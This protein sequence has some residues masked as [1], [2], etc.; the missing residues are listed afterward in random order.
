MSLAEKPRKA[1]RPFWPE[2]NGA[3]RTSFAQL[4]L[5]ARITRVEPGTLATGWR[6]LATCWFSPRN[7]NHESWLNNVKYG[8]IWENLFQNIPNIWE[9][10]W[11]YLL[12]SSA[13]LNFGLFSGMSSWYELQ[14]T[15]LYATRDAP[16]VSKVAEP[17]TSCFSGS[18]PSGKF[19]NK[20]WW[21]EGCSLGHGDMIHC[22]NCTILYPTMLQFLL[23]REWTSNPCMTTHIHKLWLIHWGTGELNGWTIKCQVCCLPSNK[24]GVEISW[25]FPCLYIS[26]NGVFSIEISGLFFLMGQDHATS[27]AN[28]TGISPT[29]DPHPKIDV[30]WWLMFIM[31]MKIL[32][33]NWF[34]MVKK[35]NML[36]QSAIL[37]LNAIVSI[38][39]FKRQPCQLQQHHM[40]S[41][42]EKKTVPDS[43]QTYPLVNVHI[44]MENHHV[45]WVN[46]L[47]QWPFSIANC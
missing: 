10:T 36:K 38:K 14:T 47:F 17:I 30:W 32:Y 28:I 16:P 40:I 5:M 34:D 42:A 43:R 19:H 18:I 25:V 4:A 20:T 27:C 12:W 39:I 3:F 22:C 44:T 41:W 7:C 9:N 11:K 6:S 23:W 37:A 35:C 46:P 13:A 2:A 15:Q 31:P 45:Q 1:T 33:Q 26:E 24:R 29:P 21:T 8:D